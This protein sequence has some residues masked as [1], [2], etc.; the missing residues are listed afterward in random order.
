M[1]SQ[2]R[3]FHSILC[4]FLLTRGTP[5]FICW[6]CRMLR[7]NDFS[8]EFRFKC[9]FVALVRIANFQFRIDHSTRIF[10]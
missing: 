6:R 4:D 2:Y 9:D 10:S 3:A 7:V 1:I 5:T 8:E